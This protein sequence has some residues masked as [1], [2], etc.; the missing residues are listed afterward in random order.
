MQHDP[1]PLLLHLHRWTLYCINL[2]PTPLPHL[3][4]QTH[5][6]LVPL[7]HYSLYRPRPPNNHLLSPHPSRN[8]PTNS[9]TLSLLPLSHTIVSYVISTAINE[10]GVNKA[11]YTNYRA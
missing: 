5:T 8:L 4:R 11:E 7:H 6:P 10:Y 3:L 1:H 9:K 2:K